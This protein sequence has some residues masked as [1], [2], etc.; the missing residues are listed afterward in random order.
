MTC[1]GGGTG[2]EVR[3]NGVLKGP[4]GHAERSEAS[5]W[6][7]VASAVVRMSCWIH[8]CAQHDRRV[9]STSLTGPSR[10][11]EFP[12]DDV[13]AADRGTLPA[14]FTSPIT[15]AFTHS[16]INRMPSVARPWLPIC[17]MMPFFFAASRNARASPT[18]WV[19][20]FST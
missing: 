12:G 3:A 15:P 7:Y 6:S 13:S 2:G 16:F 19:S 1:S 18:L 14:H 4:V 11:R 8:R 10:V 20:G 17:E 5:T 9:G